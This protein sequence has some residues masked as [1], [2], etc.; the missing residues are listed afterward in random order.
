AD[1]DKEVCGQFKLIDESLIVNPENRGIQNVV[2]YLHTGRGGTKIAEVSPRNQEVELTAENCRFDP[3]IVV[4][5]TGDTLV[6]NPK[7]AVGHNLN[8]GFFRNPPMG[9]IIPPGAPRRFA[10]TFPEPAPIP[11]ECNIH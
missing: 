6:F 5:Q 4:A 10:L 2:V 11:L 7:S 9:I 8:V 3:H 1:W